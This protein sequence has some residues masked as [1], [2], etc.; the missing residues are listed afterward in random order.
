VPAG[1]CRPALLDYTQRRQEARLE[2]VPSSSANSGTQS[3]DQAYTPPSVHPGLL[4]QPAGN[5]TNETPWCQARATIAPRRGRP[6]RIKQVRSGFLSHQAN[7]GSLHT[8]ESTA[9]A[10]RHPG[11][12]PRRWCP[13]LSP[14]MAALHRALAHAGVS[15]IDVPGMAA[16]APTKATGPTFRTSFLSPRQELAR[17]FALRTRAHRHVPFPLE[18]EGGDIVEISGQD[19]ATRRYKVTDIYPRVRRYADIC[20]TDRGR[21]PLPPNVD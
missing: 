18:S 16:E 12:S 14:Q 20:P 15:M 17:V 19:G 10:W 1:R 2:L 4:T 3:Q 9:R 8:P 13:P 6:V 11:A 21:S 7:A 5:D